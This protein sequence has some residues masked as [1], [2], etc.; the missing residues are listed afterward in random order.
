MQWRNGAIFLFTWIFSGFTSVAQVKQNTFEKLLTAPKSYVIFHTTDAITVDGKPLE[1]S[2][3][4]ARWSDKFVDI[5][6]ADKPRP[7]Y[8]TR[9]KMLWDQQ[10]LFVYA[11]LEEPHIWAY[12][13]TNDM[14]VF[15][16]NDFEIF[17]DPTR[18]THNY[19]EFEI[20]AQNVILDLVMNKAY[21]SDGTFN[22][23]WNAEGFRSAVH[24]EGTLNDPS[25]MDTKWCVEMQIPFSSLSTND[26]YVQPQ[27][28]SLWKINFSRV[29]WQTEVKNG[30]YVKK[31]DPETGKN[32]HENN[33]VWSPQGVIN[34]HYPERWGLVRFSEKPAGSIVD[35]ELP[36]DEVLRKYLWETYYHQQQFRRAHKRFATSLNELKMAESGEDAGLTFQLNMKADSTKFLLTLTADNGLVITIDQEGFAQQATK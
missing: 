23:H 28:G 20:N 7:T 1:K 29:Q 27:D 5:E 18:D 26:E 9:F 13:D 36:D 6:G 15:H 8:S 35:F 24:L 10:S 4:K 32:L 17:L 21:R 25:D 30:K 11:E 19:Y 31:K 34:M 16:E 14:I 2:W 3:Q 22:L 12:Y 33:W